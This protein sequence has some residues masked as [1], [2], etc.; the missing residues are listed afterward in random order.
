MVW[1]NS[2]KCSG[3][4]LVRLLKSVLLEQLENWIVKN[5]LSLFVM[6]YQNL[7]WINK[8]VCVGSN[9]IETT[10]SLNINV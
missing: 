6:V 10:V 3:V 9:P 7:T 2:V 4:D 5:N 1:N 8:D